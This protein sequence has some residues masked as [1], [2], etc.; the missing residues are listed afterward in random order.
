MLHAY[1]IEPMK[2]RTRRPRFVSM[3]TRK[4]F[5]ANLVG[6]MVERFPEAPDRVSALSD[7][8]GLSR[9]AIQRWI[10]VDGAGAGID[11]IGVLANALHCEPYE[12]LIP[13]RFLSAPLGPVADP[14]LHLRRARARK[15]G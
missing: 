13:D 1:A 15:P 5:A 6:R 12:L 4:A 9:S 8:S 11:A 10:E 2:G 14:T 7:A 3:A